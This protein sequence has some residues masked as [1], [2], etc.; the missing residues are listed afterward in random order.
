LIDPDD[1]TDLHSAAIAVQDALGVLVERLEVLLPEPELEPVSEPVPDAVR[2][3]AEAP[4]EPT[5]R[6]TIDIPESLHTRIK[7]ACGANHQKMADAVR[8]LLDEH[9]PEAA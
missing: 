1:L 8:A 3:M 2:F 5:K 6:L 4:A 9:W 7:L